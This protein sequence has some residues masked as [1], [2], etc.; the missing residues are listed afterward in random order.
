[1]IYIGFS[2]SRSI[3][4]KLVRWATGAAWSH[5]WIEYPSH[6]WGGRWVAH[7]AEN[8]VVKVPA[9][10]YLASCE[11]VKRF[12]VKV[13]ITKGLEACREFVGRKYDYKVIWNALV[14]VIHRVT[15]WQWLYKIVSKDSSKLTCSE[16]VS[17]ILKE[18]GV[19]GTEGMDPEL[20]TP[21]DL[22]RFCSSSPIFGV[23]Q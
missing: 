15:K 9:E 22:E 4:S 7:S 1:M 18:A 17:S 16:F 10:P 12:E 13:D 20:T 3:R 5:V 19:I 6:A 8:G 11:A 21:G 2:R 23:V 14:G